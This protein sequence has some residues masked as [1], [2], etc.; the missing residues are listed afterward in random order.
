MGSWP[1]GGCLEF[2]AIERALSLF[3]GRPE[4]AAAICFGGVTLHILVDFCFL[5]L[6][7]AAAFSGDVGFQKAAGMGRW[8]L[9]PMVILGSVMV[10]QLSGGLI[11]VWKAEASSLF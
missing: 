9:L 10:G 11:G 2:S 7:F 5:L 8:V 6:C 1:L 4:V 3:F